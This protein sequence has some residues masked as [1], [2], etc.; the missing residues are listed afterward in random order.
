MSIIII[1]YYWHDSLLLARPVQPRA[2]HRRA[3]PPPFGPE[4]ISFGIDIMT[5]ISN[6]LS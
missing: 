2:L 4:G 6:A 3:G 1:V 5:T